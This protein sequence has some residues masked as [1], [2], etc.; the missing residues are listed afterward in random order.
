[1]DV[2]THPLPQDLLTSLMRTR[3]LVALT[4]PVIYS[5]IIPFALIDLWISLYQAVCFPVYR[6]DQVL[7]AGYFSL[8]RAKLPYL[9]A[10]EKLNCVYC[11]YVTGVIAYTREIAARTEQY[12]CPIKHA[13][14]RPDPHER[15]ADF[16]AYGERET[17]AE[18]KSQLRDALRPR[19]ASTKD[20]ATPYAVTRAVRPTR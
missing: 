20:A 12:W 2:E 19:P 10:L 9:N 1:M 5:L 15:Y 18:R 14:Q 6:I 7:R 11:S 13:D 17:L 3:P 4:S 16:A 8:D